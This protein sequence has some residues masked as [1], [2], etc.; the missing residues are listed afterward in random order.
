MFPGPRYG[1]HQIQI[2]TVCCTGA[3]DGTSSSA[4]AHRIGKK[5]RHESKTRG[6]TSRQQEPFAKV[7]SNISRCN[8]C[9]ERQNHQRTVYRVGTGSDTSSASTEHSHEIGKKCG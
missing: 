8:R 7:S 1:S 6:S 3:D 5:C 4:G 2:T 9:D